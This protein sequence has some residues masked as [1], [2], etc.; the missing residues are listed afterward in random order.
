MDKFY[1]KSWTNFKKSGQILKTEIKSDFL[2]RAYSES[3]S[4]LV[5]FESVD[6]EEHFDTIFMFVRHRFE[7]ISSLEKNFPLS[8]QIL[9][10][11][12]LQ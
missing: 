8:G 5:S 4:K 6:F 12:T 9:K 7:E 2:D 10:T 1:E 11:I 3:A